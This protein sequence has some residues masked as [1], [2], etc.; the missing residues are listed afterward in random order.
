MSPRVS[1]N[2]WQWEDD[3]PMYSLPKLR[4]EQTA[5]HCSLIK[6]SMYLSVKT[7]KIQILCLNY[8]NSNSMFKP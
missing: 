3:V 8:E 7:L 4:N 6:I 5:Y 2:E 1:D